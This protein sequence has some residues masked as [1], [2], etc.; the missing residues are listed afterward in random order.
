MKLKTLRLSP[1]S[2]IILWGRL[3]RL[4]VLWVRTAH[5]SRGMRLTT[6]PS[7][8]NRMPKEEANPGRV[9]HFLHFSS[10]RISHF[11]WELRPLLHFP[12]PGSPVTTVV[13]A[14][15]SLFLFSSYGQAKGKMPTACLFFSVMSLCE[16]LADLRLRKDVSSHVPGAKTIGQAVDKFLNS[17]REMA[18]PVTF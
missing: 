6:C 15:H 9:Y 17:L 1:S 4:E 8:W 5:L 2:T 16:R 18:S 13:F 14:W 12:A 7:S 3:S 10:S 11:C